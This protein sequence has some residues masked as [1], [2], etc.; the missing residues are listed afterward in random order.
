M[1]SL[2]GWTPKG[3][4]KPINHTIWWDELCTIIAR[5]IFLLRGRVVYSLFC[6]FFFFSLLC[7]Q[8]FTQVF[9]AMTE[10][11]ALALVGWM[12]GRTACSQLDL[13]VLLCPF[14]RG[15]LYVSRISKVGEVV[16]P[17]FG[18]SI[19]GRR[20]TWIILRPKSW[21]L[22]VNKHLTIASQ[23]PFHFTGDSCSNCP[24]HGGGGQKL[25]EKKKRKVKI[26]N[27]VQV[28]G[29]AAFNAI[30]HAGGR[31]GGVKKNGGEVRALR[32]GSAGWG[33]AAGQ[34]APGSEAEPN[35][36]VRGRSLP[37]RCR[38]GPGARGAGRPGSPRL[39]FGGRG[40]KRSRRPRV[41]LGFA[42]ERGSRERSRRAEP[43]ARGRSS[44]AGAARLLQSLRGTTFL[45]GPSMNQTAGVSNNV[46]CSSGKGPKVSGAAQLP[47]LPS[48]N[49]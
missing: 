31:E 26:K 9:V 7:K 8:I 25:G 20:L 41:V 16:Q 27:R 17:P 44:A 11:A 40:R 33:R 30:S 23:P 47:F 24:K 34:R 3:K 18:S 43:R 1:I 38:G 45:P 39:C 2:D 48:L 12:E 14:Q 36:T 49:P 42:L 10:E 35:R 15:V 5:Q 37:P 19:P 6:C 22:R 32:W 4:K 21:G 29:L 13:M 46:R 28:E